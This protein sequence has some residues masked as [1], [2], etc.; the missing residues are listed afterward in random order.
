MLGSD[1]G[2]QKRIWGGSA[3]ESDVAEAIFRFIWTILGS[4]FRHFFGR[5]CDPLFD[6]F[7]DL[8]SMIFLLIFDRSGDGFSI[9]PSH[10]YHFE[11][12]RA[13]S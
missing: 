11:R 8:F 9:A 2:P 12:R 5:F 3:S 13:T 6:L 10:V 4:L 1:G 7:F